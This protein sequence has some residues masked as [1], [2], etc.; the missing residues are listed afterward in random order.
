MGGKMEQL[1]QI[2]KRIR[3]GDLLAPAFF[4]TIDCD[5]V[6]DARDRD[7]SFETAWLRLSADVN[8]V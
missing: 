7:Q 4:T 5:A 1:N 6:I 8:R 2:L 3:T